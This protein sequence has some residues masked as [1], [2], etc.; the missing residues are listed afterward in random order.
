MMTRREKRLQILKAQ[1]SKLD[2]QIAD[3][4]DGGVLDMNK[5]LTLQILRG[6]VFR[7][8]CKLEKKT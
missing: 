8:I 6:Q 4:L 3:I 5:L 7:S 2:A 1:E